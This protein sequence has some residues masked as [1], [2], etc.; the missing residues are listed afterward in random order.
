MKRIKFHLFSERSLF[1]METGDK[2]A[3]SEF[4]QVILLTRFSS[5]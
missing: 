3:D 5:Y 4:D 1:T 2:V